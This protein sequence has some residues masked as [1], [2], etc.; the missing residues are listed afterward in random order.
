MIG[1]GIAGAV[2]QT[3]SRA[4]SLV[5]VYGIV[6]FTLAFAVCVWVATYRVAANGHRIE[7][8]CRNACAPLNGR[9]V[10]HLDGTVSCYCVHLLPPE[11]P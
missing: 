8:A 4:L 11:A 2:R 6:A 9:L 5:A 7:S 3:L 10:G 1:G